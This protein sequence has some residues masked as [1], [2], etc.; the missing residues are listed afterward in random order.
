MYTIVPVHLLFENISSYLKLLTMQIL[1]KWYVIREKLSSVL[2]PASQKSI[3]LA[4]I[5]KKVFKNCE[6]AGLCYL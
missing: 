4:A 3:N 6:N 5:F 2:D 1:G